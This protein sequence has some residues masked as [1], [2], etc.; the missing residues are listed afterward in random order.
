V[1]QAASDSR[2]SSSSPISGAAPNSGR[3]FIS[4]PVSGCFTGRE[5]PVKTISSLPEIGG[6]IPCPLRPMR[7][8]Y[9]AKL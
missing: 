9:A 6:E 1:I 3:G 4:A 8:K 5:L 2:G 7:E